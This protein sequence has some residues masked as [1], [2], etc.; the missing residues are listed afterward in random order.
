MLKCFSSAVTV[1]FE[2]E[3]MVINASFVFFERVFSVVET[4]GKG[5]V[6]SFVME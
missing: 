6:F 2:T 5:L 1:C 4:L 3:R